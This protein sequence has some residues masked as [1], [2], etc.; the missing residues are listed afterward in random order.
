MTNK[1]KFLALVSNEKTNT[2]KGNKERIKNR[3]ILL[4]SQ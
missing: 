4:E 3:V 1:D 2:L